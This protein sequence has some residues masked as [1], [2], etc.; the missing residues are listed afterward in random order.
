M[1][2]PEARRSR[3]GHLYDL[4]AGAETVEFLDG[5][6]R[7][8]VEHMDAQVSCGL[9]AYKEGGTVTIASSD[10]VA[11]EL[12]RGQDAAGEGPR[13]EAMS[14][15]HAV[16]VTDAALLDKWPAWWDL[17]L[18]RGVRQCLSLPMIAKDETVGAVTLY[19]ST[20]APFSVDD[21]RGAELF[22]GYATGALMIAIRLAEMA[23]LT[24]HLE[25]ALESRAVIDQAKGI[26]M[27]EQHCAA[28]EAFMILRKASQ[29]QNL[30]LR[31]LAAQ[32]VGRVSG[33]QHRGVS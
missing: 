20:D 9:S 22:A 8:A 24:G 27:A 12:E 13:T 7:M 2:T 5:L 19:A 26:I 15:G 30:P 33:R 4:L 3:I 17:A 10:D 25:T 31:H 32:L 18:S 16:H 21:R 29:N 23:E 28:D 6:A 1:P 11:A 14:T